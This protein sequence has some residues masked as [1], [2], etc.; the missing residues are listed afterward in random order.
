MKINVGIHYKVNVVV[1][2]TGKLRVYYG[3]D[4]YLEI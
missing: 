3:D 2:H 4:Q 1:M